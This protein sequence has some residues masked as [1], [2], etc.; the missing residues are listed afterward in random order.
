MRWPH[1]LALAAVASLALAGCR[2]EDTRFVEVPPAL[3][4]ADPE[5]GR[6]ALRLHGCVTCHVAPGVVGGDQRVG[7]T[8]EGFAA[9]RYVAG[10]LPNTPDNAIRWIVAPQEIA[11]GSAMPDLGVDVETAR[12]IVAY[13]RSQSDIGS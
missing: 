5:R 6:L 4:G 7:P 13:L 10:S 9:R 11:P 1:A 12:D 2:D 8:L 3:V